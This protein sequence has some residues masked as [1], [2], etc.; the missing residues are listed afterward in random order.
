MKKIAFNIATI[1][2]SSLVGLYLVEGTVIVSGY[3][4][5]NNSVEIADS[6]GVSFDKRTK[7]EVF[8]DLHK[9]YRGGYLL[10]LIH[11]SLLSL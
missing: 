1:L 3:F 10:P 7:L 8:E 2:C 4:D 6:Q 11:L 9:L 5:S